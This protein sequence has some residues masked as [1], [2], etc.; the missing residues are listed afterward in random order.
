M[1]D[2][3]LGGDRRGEGRAPLE[4]LG[5]LREQPQRHARLARAMRNE[6]VGLG[7]GVGLGVGLGLGFKLLSADPMFAI[8][9]VFVL[10]P[11]LSC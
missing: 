4:L 11:K 8:I 2:E 5:D 3:D 7:L 1:V 6:D 10:P 9:T